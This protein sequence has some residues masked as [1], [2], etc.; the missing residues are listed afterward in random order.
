MSY[1]RVNASAET[2]ISDPRDPHHLTGTAAGRR[3]YGRLYASGKTKSQTKR[4]QR[5]GRWTEIPQR[6]LIFA[7]FWLDVKTRL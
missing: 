4:G 5:R 7:P 2:R 3:V 6:P 1:R